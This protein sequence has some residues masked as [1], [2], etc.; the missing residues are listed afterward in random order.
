MFLGP[1]VKLENGQTAHVTLKNSLTEETTVHWHG[2]IV[3][4]PADGGPHDVIR[5]SEEKE[6]TSKVQQDRS[7]L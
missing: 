5:P 4:D 3:G 1:I 2:L 7:T 6:I